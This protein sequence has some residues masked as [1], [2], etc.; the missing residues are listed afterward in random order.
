MSVESAAIRASARRAFSRLTCHAIT[1]AAAAT[2]SEMIV[3]SKR[4]VFMAAP[5]FYR[6][7]EL[8]GDLH[9]DVHRRAAP[10][11]RLESPLTHRL[12]GTVVELGAEPSP[13]PDVV[14]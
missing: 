7:F 5:S 4:D 2:T 8:D 11:S 12:H 3:R 13:N 14:G 10:A 6:K 1:L 9:G